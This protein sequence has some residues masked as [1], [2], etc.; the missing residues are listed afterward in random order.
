MGTALAASTIVPA[1]TIDACTF[2]N[3]GSGNKYLFLD[4]NANKLILN[5][6]NSIFANSPMPGGTIQGT[7]FRA[8]ASGNVLN[9]TNN[10]YFNLF[11]TST[12][13]QA[14]L[15]LTGLNQVAFNTTNLGWTATTTNFS[16]QS[17][18][19]NSKIF[20]MSSGGGAVGDPRW[21]Y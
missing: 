10:N 8:S 6:R 19:A 12:G 21:T 15:G 9:F 18:P 7:A 17:Q 4:A 20:S 2:N 5:I 11:S 13:T 14:P 16:L 1:V 3:F